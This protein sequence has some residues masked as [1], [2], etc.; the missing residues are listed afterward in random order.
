[1]GIEDLRA[2]SEEGA[3]DYEPYNLHALALME[4]NRADV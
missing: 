2:E 1:M 3:D 4:D